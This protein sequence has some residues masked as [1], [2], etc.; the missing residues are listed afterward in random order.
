MSILKVVLSGRHSCVSVFDALNQ[1]L[2]FPYGNPDWDSMSD[3]ISVLEW[4]DEGTDVEIVVAKNFS[5]AGEGE[6]EKMISAF[7]AAYSYNKSQGYPSRLVI[8]LE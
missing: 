6:L 2:K 4:L 5:L 7:G 1:E 3:A 8:H